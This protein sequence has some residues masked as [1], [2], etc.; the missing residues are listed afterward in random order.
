MYTRILVPLDGSQVAENALDHA[1][2]MADIFG[3]ELILLR[4]AFLD[5]VP[6][7]DLSEVQRVLVQ[8]SEAYLNQVACQL[9]E[10]GRCVR[11]A[12]RWSKAAEAITAYAVAQE[13]SVVVMATHGHSSHEHWPMGSIAEKVLRSMQVPV[14]LVR[15]S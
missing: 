6:D 9:Q 3:A 12:V 5:R 10:D 2:Q 8:E 13:I 1:A 7:F 11:T 4:A 14:L 15:P